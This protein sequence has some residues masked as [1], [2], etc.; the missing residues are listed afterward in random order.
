MFSRLINEKLIFIN[1]EINLLLKAIIQKM[2]K[3]QRTK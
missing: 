3:E 1:C 2:F